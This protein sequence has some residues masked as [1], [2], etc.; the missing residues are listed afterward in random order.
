M[1][2]SAN[3]TQRWVL[4]S[5]A[6]AL[7]SILWSSWFLL[8]SSIG[9]RYPCK[10]SSTAIMSFFGTIQSAA[11]VGLSSGRNLSVWIFRGTFEIIAILFTVIAT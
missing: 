10:Y 3:R 2:S 9:R 1:L 5:M 6:L 11:L 4:S 8:Q 7:G